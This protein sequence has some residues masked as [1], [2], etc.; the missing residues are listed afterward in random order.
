MQFHGGYVSSTETIAR[1]KKHI[2]LVI[3]WVYGAPITRA[4]ELRQREMLRPSDRSEQTYNN[5]LLQIV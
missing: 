2:G 3:H 4:D 1:Y 5:D